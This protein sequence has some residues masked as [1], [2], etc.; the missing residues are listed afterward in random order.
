MAAVG[1]GCGSNSGQAAKGA[2]PAGGGAAAGAQV[3]AACGSVMQNPEDEAA[4]KEF[5]TQISGVW[6]DT[7]QDV[8]G[9]EKRDFTPLAEKLR[10]F[11][12][13]LKNK[14]FGPTE[15]A[16]AKIKTGLY[17]SMITPLAFKTE[18]IYLSKSNDGMRV[19]QGANSDDTLCWEADID[20]DTTTLRI[21][22]LNTFSK[23]ASPEESE[24]VQIIP[25]ERLDP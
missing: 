13:D 21:S 2:A 1:A 15:I 8:S 20:D 6:V 25:Y 7:D 9:R 24:S 11:V 16:H 19:I 10:G 3:V 18:T 17:M 12:I 23:G 14:S 22:H 5:L 4:T